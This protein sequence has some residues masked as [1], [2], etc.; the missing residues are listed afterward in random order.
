MN[1]QGYSQSHESSEVTVLRWIITLAYTQPANR[2]KTCV[3][4][5]FSIQSQA[6]AHNLQ[7]ARDWGKKTRS[8]CDQKFRYRPCFHFAFKQ[9]K[10]PKIFS[11]FWQKANKEPKLIYCQS[12][13]SLEGPELK[14][15]VNWQLV[16][17]P[18]RIRPRRS[19]LPSFTPTERLAVLE[20]AKNWAVE[21]IELAGRTVS[22]L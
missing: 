15:K 2:W 6:A 5:F 18:P 11:V 10:K 7:D 8:T 20:T 22:G 19:W 4:I 14:L 9:F 1:R 13:L 17:V 3:L 12:Y 16:N 21:G